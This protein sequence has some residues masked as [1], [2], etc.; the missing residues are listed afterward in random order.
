MSTAVID[1]CPVVSSIDDNGTQRITLLDA[2]DSVLCG[3]YKPP[4]HTY[5]RPYMSAALARVGPQTV[6]MPAQHVLA[7]RPTGHGRSQSG[8]WPAKLWGH[9]RTRSTGPATI[10]SRRRLRIAGRLPPE[11][12]LEATPNPPRI[13]PGRTSPSSPTSYLRRT[14]PPP[15]SALRRSTATNCGRHRGIHRRRS[16]RRGRAASRQ[17]NQFRSVCDPA[18]CAGLTVLEPG[19]AH[20]QGRGIP[21]GV[22]C[23]VYRAL[24]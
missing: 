17:A 19:A 13:P 8:T 15:N 18:R 23:A 7:P 24:V 16:L 11:S 6:L 4:G 22:S 9:S 5:W 1:L 21:R 14:L 20:G 10:T 2:D 3:A 12:G